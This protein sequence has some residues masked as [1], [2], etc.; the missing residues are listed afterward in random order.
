MPVPC[1][2]VGRPSAGQAP[3]S[4]CHGLSGGPDRTSGLGRRHWS[5]V[6]LRLVLEGEDSMET[7]GA[8]LAL[9]PGSGDMLC[10]T[11]VVA[12]PTAL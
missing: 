5:R 6:V 12:L 3:I 7:L 1:V 4:C 10:G 2:G 9:D 8:L 11:G